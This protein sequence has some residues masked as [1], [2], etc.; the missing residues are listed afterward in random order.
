MAWN[1]LTCW[2]CFKLVQKAQ[3]MLAAGG[4]LACVTAASMEGGGGDRQQ[5][6]VGCCLAGGGSALLFQN[7]HTT[8]PPH[9]L[10]RAAAKCGQNELQLH[11][12]QA[13][14]VMPNAGACTMVVT[15]CDVLRVQRQSR[16]YM[17]GFVIN[18]F[19][20]QCVGC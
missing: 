19:C 4:I 18:N 15:C 7:V 9:L 8:G 12:L 20:F 2:C 17:S 16:A 13:L 5:M 6:A 1:M 14:E 11:C 3:A 10:E